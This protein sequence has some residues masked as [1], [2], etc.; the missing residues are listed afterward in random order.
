[1]NLYFTK[2]NL[3]LLYPGPPHFTLN[4]NLYFTTL[5]DTLPHRSL[6]MI[7]TLRDITSPHHTLP[8][9]P[10]PWIWSSLYLTRPYITAQ[11]LTLRNR[12]KSYRTWI[13]IFTLPYITWLHLAILCVT[14]EYDLHFT[15]LYNTKPNIAKPYAT[16]QYETLY[17][18]MNLY[19]TLPD[20]AL[21]NNTM[22]P[23]T[24]LSYWNI[25]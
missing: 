8:N 24:P 11:Y 21:L 14:N 4:I 16:L 2:L 6:N 10:T 15:L 19:P 3:T 1:M 5:H 23:S 7:L 22:P 18:N 12:S 25:I 20:K 9:R 13:W 17:W